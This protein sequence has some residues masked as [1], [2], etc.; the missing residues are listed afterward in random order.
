MIYLN[1]NK[2]ESKKLNTFSGDL[3]VSLN[4]LE[5]CLID[6]DTD[7]LTAISQDDNIFGRLVTKIETIINSDKN[8]KSFLE[9]N[10]AEKILVNLHL[11]TIEV[12]TKY[13][14]ENLIL[15]GI[16][17]ELFLLKDNK[18]LELNSHIA[19]ETDLCIY[20]KDIQFWIYRYGEFERFIS[21]KK[22]NSTKNNIFKTSYKYIVLNKSLEDIIL[23]TLENFEVE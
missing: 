23:E 14:T 20:L 15:K 11:G 4:D 6:I 12:Q 10:N 18:E 19:F 1:K 22:T 17:L 13:K 21:F 16:N 7:N 9:I 8:I 2:A 5:E 3:I